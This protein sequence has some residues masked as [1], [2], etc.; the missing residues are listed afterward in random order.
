MLEAHIKDGRDKVPMQVFG[1]GKAFG[2]SV[3]GT[4]GLFASLVLAR[5]SRTGARATGIC[6]RTTLGSSSPA[7]S[8]TGLG[9]RGSRWVLGSSRCWWIWS[10]LHRRVIGTMRW[11]RWMHSIVVRRTFWWSTITGIVRVGSRSGLVIVASS[12]RRCPWIMSR[13]WRLK[14]VL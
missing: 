7:T 11:R 6:G 9:G 3:I 10:M 8:T 14:M 12:R 5:A 13:G 1:P 2:P 4:L